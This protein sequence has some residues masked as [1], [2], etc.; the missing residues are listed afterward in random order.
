MAEDLRDGRLDFRV[1]ALG[2]AWISTRCIT[3]VVVI[4]AAP[5]RGRRR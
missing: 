5:P 3:S 4:D 1:G 2:K